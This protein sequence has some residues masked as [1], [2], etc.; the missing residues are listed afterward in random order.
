MNAFRDW[1]VIPEFASATDVLIGQLPS[2]LVGVH[3]RAEG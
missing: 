3:H 2:F 1:I